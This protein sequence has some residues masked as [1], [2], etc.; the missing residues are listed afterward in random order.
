MS[1]DS[2]LTVTMLC[3]SAEVATLTGRAGDSIRDEDI[4]SHAPKGS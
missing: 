3:Y 1:D 2:A 4:S